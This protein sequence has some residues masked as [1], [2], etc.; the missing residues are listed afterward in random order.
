M[1]AKRFR[2]RFGFPALSFLR[3]TAVGDRIEEVLIPFSWRKPKLKAIGFAAW[4][5]LGSWFFWNSGAFATASRIWEPVP[6]PGGMAMFGGWLLG[7][8]ILAR[9]LLRHR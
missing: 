9:K 3:P 4:V 5:I 2:K 7:L 8:G 6:E 1:D